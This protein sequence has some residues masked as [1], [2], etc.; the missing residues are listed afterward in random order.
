MASEDDVLAILKDLIDRLHN[1]DSQYK[2]MLPSRR[3][4]EAECTDLGLVYHAVWKSGEL[5]HIEEGAAS[6]PDIR[7]EIDSDDLMEM[8]N[9]DLTFRRAYSQNRIRIDAPMRDLLRLRA[10]L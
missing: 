7:I 8:A 10:V 5:T 6:R 1:L 4:I 9:G 2:G 3:T